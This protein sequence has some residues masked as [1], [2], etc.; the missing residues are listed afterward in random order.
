MNPPKPD[1]EAIVLVIE[2][3]DTG[4]LVANNLGES[5]DLALDC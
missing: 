4:S 3:Q 5:V 2:L 1:N